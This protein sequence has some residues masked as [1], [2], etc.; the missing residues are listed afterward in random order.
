MAYDSFGS[1]VKRGFLAMPVAIR[2]IIGINTAIF[3]AQIL[4]SFIGISLIQWFAF[5][6]DPITVVTQPWRLFTYMFTHSL[7][8]PFH[9]IFNMLWLWWMGRPV[10]ETIGAHSFFSIY[11]GAGLIGALIDVIVSLLGVPNPVIGASGAV[12][13]VM[14]AFAMLYPRTPI[15]LLLLPPLEARYVVTGIIALDVLLLNSGGNVAR[16]VHLGG[17]LGGY[18]LM[19]FRQKGGDISLIPRYFDYLYSTHLSKILSPLFALLNVS[20]KTNKDGRGVKSSMHSWRANQTQSNR[21]RTATRRGTAS[22]TAGVSDAEILEEVE[23]SELDT[24]LD[25]ISKSGYNA[26]S[27]QEKKTLFELSKRKEP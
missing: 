9:F 27:K 10:E 13:G 12:Y 20:V 6:P 8:N 25:K 18:G 14:V 15:M 21:N 24:I 7:L 5:V 26:L 23:Q 11:L 17:A 2:A 4:S 22:N 16:F 19:K 1:S 3:F